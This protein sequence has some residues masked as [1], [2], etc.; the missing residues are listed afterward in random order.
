MAD[1]TLTRRA[2][3]WLYRNYG[4]DW[5]TSCGPSSGDVITDTCGTSSP[6]SR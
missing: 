4:R 3:R 1:D 2:E 5:R 6:M